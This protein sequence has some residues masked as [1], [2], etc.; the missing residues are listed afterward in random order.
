MLFLII[1]TFQARAELATNFSGVAY[2]CNSTNN[3]I[4]WRNWTRGT[5][6]EAETNSFSLMGSTTCRHF[7]ADYS[8]VNDVGVICTTDADADFN[9]ALVNTTTGIRDNKPKQ[10][11]ER[12]GNVLEYVRRMFNFL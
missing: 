6:F 3:L 1:L 2:W 9:C 5:G 11:A 10:P 7:T 8:R 4:Y 12:G